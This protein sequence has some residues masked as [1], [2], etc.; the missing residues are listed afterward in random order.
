M[1]KKLFSIL[2]VS[3]MVVSLAACGSS[4]DSDGSSD[5]GS[6]D[7]TD[8]SDTA[9]ENSSGETYSIS[10]ILKTL[11]SEVSGY[12]QAG[13]EAYD[14]EHDNVTIDVKGPTSQT[15]Y[16]EQLNM[17]E[18][19]LNSGAYDAMVIAPL[20]ADS[21]ATMIEG[22]DMPILAVDGDI[23]SDDVLAYVGIGNYDAAYAGAEE[24]V[25]AAEEAGWDEINAICIA[26][27]EGDE[28]SED[29][30]DGFMDGTEAAGGTFLEDETQYGDSVADK[31]VTCMEGIIQNHPDGVAIVYCIN[32]DMAMAAQKAASDYEAYDNTIFVG[33]DGI[34]S[35]CESI[36]EGEETMSVSMEAY[37]MG[38]KA[39]EVAVAAIEGEE[40]DDFYDTG[41]TIVTQENA[42]ER[43]DLL[44]TF[45][46]DDEEE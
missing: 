16:D 5:T 17:I 31:A 45:V 46:T 2:L 28:V 27:V 29:R 14:E 22:T 38:Y 12:I 19:D 25:A 15:A 3:T 21:V 7:E 24:A 32:D 6:T 39:A 44:S 11:S 35:A 36:L 4:D 37:D 20:Q 34:I 43:I 41:Y 9:E 40:L 30:I 23:D 33:F 42:Q 10:I 18:T 13:A 1:K 26:G 8:S